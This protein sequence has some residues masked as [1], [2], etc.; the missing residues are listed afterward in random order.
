MNFEYP[1]PKF[2]SLFNI[3]YSV[4]DIN[5]S[6]L[7]NIGPRVLLRFHFTNPQ[8]DFRLPLSPPKHKHPIGRQSQRC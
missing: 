7:N 2:T 8:I 1:T 4:F 3:L 6:K 5:N